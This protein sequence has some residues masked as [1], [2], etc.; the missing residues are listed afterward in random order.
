M[1]RRNRYQF[2]EQTTDKPHCLTNPIDIARLL[3]IFVL[4]SNKNVLPEEVQLAVDDVLHLVLV[5]PHQHPEQSQC[6]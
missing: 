2:L 4:K 6:K 1:K 3:G 5:L